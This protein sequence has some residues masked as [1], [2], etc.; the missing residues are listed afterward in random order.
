MGKKLGVVP[1]TWYLNESP[2]YIP[3]MI[4]YCSIWDTSLRD[5]YA[6]ISGKLCIEINQSLWFSPGVH[7][8][9][10]HHPLQQTVCRIQDA[11]KTNIVERMENV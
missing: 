6:M 2:L 1:N 8:Q 9:L 10:N 5:I 11:M 4:V 3:G 7:V